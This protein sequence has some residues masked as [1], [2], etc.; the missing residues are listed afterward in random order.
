MAETSW[1][2][3]WT[4]MGLD[5][6]TI[7]QMIIT[8]L[9]AR[10]N[11][12]PDSNNQALLNV[13][14]D[15]IIAEVDVFRKIYEWRQLENARGGALDDIAADWGVSRIDNDD[16]FLRFQI[17]LAKM[18]NRIGVTE[19]DI[20]NLIAFILQAD[21][22]EFDVITD[23]DQLGGDPEAVRFTNI[24]NRYSKSARKKNLLVKA[25][26]SAVM[27]EVKIVSVDF[28]A[29]ASQMLYVA[30]A[31]KKERSHFA[32]MDSMRDRAH[33]TDD[34]TTVATVTQRQRLHQVSK[35]G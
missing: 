18:L 23:P 35:E 22:T 3:F 27:P 8:A 13:F 9:P 34:N 15:D 25:L 4:D 17:R 29:V 16:D 28:Q 32:V 30:T 7:R 20:I 5:D 11:Q 24:P 33:T 2:T 10:K 31:T 6:D 19:N 14:A 1:S 12:S 26:E 21:P